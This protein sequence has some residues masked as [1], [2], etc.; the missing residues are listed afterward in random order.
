M[1]AFSI[2]REGEYNMNKNWRKRLQCT[3]TDFN[4]YMDAL[5]V[6]AVAFVMGRIAFGLGTYGG[7]YVIVGTSLLY[8]GCSVGYALFADTTK[9]DKKIQEKEM[10]KGV[11]ERVEQI[12]KEEVEQKAKE[13]QLEHLLELIK[14]SVRLSH[15]DMMNAIAETV[16][17]IR[18]ILQKENISIE[19]EHYLTYTLPR[20]IT[21]MIRLY[22]KLDEKR[23][24][25]KEQE[26][27]S[28]LQHVQEEL[29]EKFV[30]RYQ[31]E[32]VHLLDKKL[33]VSQ[34]RLYERE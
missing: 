27:L 14:E 18:D 21:E 7:G 12:K 19:E 8:V 24:Q 31:K 17:T 10:E 13:K 9:Y 25:C 29:Q 26:V 28:Y 5:G 2:K 11:M 20:D 6:G 3:L 33:A 16:Q 22:R 23:K 15:V 34:Q 4:I 1:R 32:T 30:E